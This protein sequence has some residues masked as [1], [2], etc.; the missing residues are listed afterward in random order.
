LSLDIDALPPEKI[1]AAI[2]RLE[3][4]KQQRA[5]E[6]KLAHYV[7]YNRQ[8]QF[9]AAGARYR[10]RLLMA[11]NQVGK[12]WAAAMETAMHVTGIYP[13][14]WEGHTF[15]RPIQ[16]WACGESNEVVRSSVQ[17]L[18]L[19]DLVGTGCIPKSALLEIVVA[20]GLGELVDIIKVQ[21]VSGGVSMISLKSYAQGRERFQGATIDF[22]WLDEEPDEDIFFEVLA[23][24]TVTAGPLIMTFTPLKGM[25]SVVKRYLNETSPDR[26][27]TKMTIDDAAHITPEMK[28]RFVAQYP[29]YL[30]D[31][32]LYGVPMVGEG[33]VFTIPEEKLF[34]AAFEHPKHWTRLGGIDFGFSHYAAFCELWHD[35][36]TDVVYLVRTLRIREATP[37]QHVEAVRHWG[38]KWAWPH[39][40]RNQTLAGA[41]VPLMRQYESAGL[42]MMPDAAKFEDGGNSVEAGIQMMID[43][44][45]GARWKVFRGQNDGWLEE[46]RMYHRKDGLLV[47]IDDDAISASRYA[48][49]CLRYGEVSIPS[50]PRSIRRGSAGGWMA[51]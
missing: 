46:Y 28:E 29:D 41:G 38:L 34:V 8:A 37:H 33:R 9:H 23:R 4:V 39:D 13:D 36:D 30:R 16:A 32:R 18:L 44:M 19:G 43:R 20:R 40:G 45:R 10:E 49:M 25:S 22:A 14:W 35:R 21:H 48:M 15:D 6:N 24:T 26:H 42:D 1:G 17:R 12:T 31:V 5:A 27:V 7:P 51:A 3:A 50:R 2:A 47:K 11:G